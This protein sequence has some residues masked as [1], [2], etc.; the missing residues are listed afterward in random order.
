MANLKISAMDSFEMYGKHLLDMTKKAA[1]SMMDGFHE[2]TDIDQESKINFLHKKGLMYASKGNYVKATPILESL[3]LAAEQGEL[4][5][6]AKV[7]F[8]LGVCYLKSGLR[9]DGITLLEGAYDVLNDVK[10]ASIL[11]ITYV[12]GQEYEKA[13]PFLEKVLT[14]SP[15]NFR[16]RYR[17]GVALDNL[18]KY[19]DAVKQFLLV[20]EANPDDPK[21]HRSIGYS[22]EKLEDRDKAMEHF[23]RANELDELGQD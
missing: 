9:E 10:T 5:K 19:Q 14:D 17:L 20:L 23:K 6:D 7:E 4:T 3:M 12:E 11:A 13:L 16:M 22:Y 1:N 18:E 2:L 15:D 21:L 8:Y